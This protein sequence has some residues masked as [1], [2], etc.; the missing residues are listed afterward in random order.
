MKKNIIKNS[1]LNKWI[2]VRWLDSGR[3]DYEWK[4]FHKNEESNISVLEVVTIGYLV[5]Y[6]ETGIKLAFNVV[7]YKLKTDYLQILGEID[8]PKVAILSIGLIQKNI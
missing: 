3:S 1:Y 7:D 5:S 6:N 8:I 4:I 2:H